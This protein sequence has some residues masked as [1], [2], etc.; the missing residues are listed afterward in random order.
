MKN[1]NTFKGISKV[2]IQD[3][4]TVRM[5]YDEWNNKTHF[6]EYPELFSYIMN[7]NTTMMQVKEIVQH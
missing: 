5:W 7:K 1:L 2:T 3:G 4:R 6:T